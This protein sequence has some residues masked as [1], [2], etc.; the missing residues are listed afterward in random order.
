MHDPLLTVA[1]FLLGASAGSII[2]TIRYRQEVADLRATL[3]TLLQQADA[4]SKY[5]A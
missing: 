5:A 3:E 4:Q 2:T 1:V